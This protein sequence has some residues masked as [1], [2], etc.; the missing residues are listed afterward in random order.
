MFVKLTA[1]RE[2]ALVSRVPKSADTG[3]A[4]HPIALFVVVFGMCVCSTRH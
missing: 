2:V 1:K 4:G 3:A